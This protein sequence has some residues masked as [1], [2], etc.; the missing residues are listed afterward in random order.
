MCIHDTRCRC[1]GSV[2]QQQFMKLAKRQYHK[3]QRLYALLIWHQ[4]DR[5][6]ISVGNKL[7]QAVSSRI[8]DEVAEAS[9]TI[10]VELAC[11]SPG[12][13]NEV[14]VIVKGVVLH[15]EVLLDP[16]TCI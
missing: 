9:R 2:F 3:I 7:T 16:V 11:F 4:S 14:G 5:L 10:V 8:D 15:W 12:I 13:R 1:A 6:R